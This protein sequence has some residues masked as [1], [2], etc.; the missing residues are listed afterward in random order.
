MLSCLAFPASQECCLLPASLHAVQ[1]VNVPLSPA[2]LLLQQPNP[3]VVEEHPNKH[4]MSEN[5]ATA[6]SRWTNLALVQSLMVSFYGYANENI[7][8]DAREAII[9]KMHGEG[10]EDLTW[11]K[12]RWVPDSFELFSQQRAFHTAILL[13]TST[14]NLHRQPRIKT[15]IMAE[16]TSSGG[17]WANPVLLE[18]LVMGFHSVTKK[19]E[20]LSK[21]A[22]DEILSKVHLWGFV[23]I[24]WEGIRL[25]PPFFLIFCLP[26]LPKHSYQTSMSR[27]TM[28]W[29]TEVDQHILVAMV[30]TFNPSSEQY[31]SVMSFLE[32]AGYGFTVS[33]LKQH[34]QKLQRKEAA[35]ANDNG[36]GPSTSAPVTPKKTPAKKAATPR[37]RKTPAKKAKSEE[38]EDDN[39][40]EP[41]PK[42][43]RAPERPTFAEDLTVVKS[44]DGSI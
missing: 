18:A 26:L 14:P 12:L 37:K 8:K 39:A 10:F 1:D 5:T 11:D 44:D 43:L 3:W 33:A 34:I 42:K 32:P 2:F 30:K 27:Q 41:T 28:K 40:E 25:L 7:D 23:D 24:T 19:E 15:F 17:K 31:D 16:K 20:G 13:A 38:D 29:T 6:S 36:E 9:Q 35:Q 21:D 22:K 4:T